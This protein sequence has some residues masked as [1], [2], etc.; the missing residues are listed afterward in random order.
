MGEPVYRSLGYRTLYHY[1]DWV[2]LTAPRPVA[3]P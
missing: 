3:S 1:E 2:R